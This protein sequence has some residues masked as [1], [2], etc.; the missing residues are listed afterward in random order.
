MFR[1]LFFLLLLF[2]AFAQ[3]TELAPWYS[4]YLELQPQAEY[5]FQ[6]YNTLNTKHGHKHRIARDNYLTLSLSGAYDVYSVE[7]ETTFASTRHVSACLADAR[8]TGRY[9]WLDDVLGDPVSLVTGVTAIQTLKIAR[10]DL[11]NF[12][13]GGIEGE[14]HLAVGRETSCQQFWISRLW[15]LFAI[16]VA[17]LGSPWIRADVAW[18][19]NGWDDHEF[20]LF[21]RSLWGLGGENLNLEKRF[22]GYGP[23]AHQSIDLGIRY[24]FLLENGGFVGIGYSYRVYANNCPRCVNQCYASLLYPFGL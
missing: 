16:G 22:K 23:I 10:H 1:K 13:H 21:A 12:Y 11:S 19:H 4:R 7:L 6:A 15:G 3:S 5:R 9:Q 17:D 24:S 20:S 14:F 8:L 2:P 18:D